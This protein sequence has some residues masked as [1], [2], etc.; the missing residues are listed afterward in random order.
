MDNVQR[1]TDRIFEHLKT[2]GIKNGDRNET[3]VFSRVDI[4]NDAE[5][6]LHAEGWYD[7]AQGER[8]AYLVIGPQ[9]GSVSK[10]A[11]NAAV[12]ACSRRADADWLV[13]LGFAFESDID[14]RSVT[15]KMGSFEVTKA[16]MHDDLM[17]EGLIKKD[18][19]AAS[20]VTIGEPDIALRR[21]AEG[22]QVE[23]KGLDIYDPVRDEVKAR[24]VADLSY[25]ML[26]DCYDGSNF[27]PTQ[28]FFC[29]GD[30]DEF[31]KFKKG[32]QSLALASVKKAAEQTLKIELD[33][34]AFE[35]L[36]GF[37]SHPLAYEKG[38]KLAV[39]VIS[40]FGEESTKVLVL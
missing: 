27:M 6:A 36:Y 39:R 10:A 38:R 4:I 23:I 21:S 13:I 7:T 8:K 37:V 16:R 25:W 14:N 28:I 17:Q 9:F 35:R 22:V 33:D 11:V 3:A 32:L 40:Q 31:A 20:F 26:D 15:R 2:A 30:K 34:E 18:K 12:K 5:G 1:F 29:G 19:K 24:S